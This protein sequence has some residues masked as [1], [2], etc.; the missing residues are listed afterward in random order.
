MLLCASSHAAGEGSPEPTPP[1]QH[2]GH[3]PSS[4]TENRTHCAS[5]HPGF[6][7][8][9]STANKGVD[10]A[11]MQ[12]H[13]VT[14]DERLGTLQD[15]VGAPRTPEQRC[16]HGTAV[17]PRAHSQQKPRNELISQALIS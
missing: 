12:F 3:R 6:E 9:G 7:A 10:S 4:S 15:A 1:G 2:F 8:T 16:W 14:Q 17:G 5:E 13:Y 11:A